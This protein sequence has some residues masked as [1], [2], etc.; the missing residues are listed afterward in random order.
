MT[1][2]RIRH[3]RPGRRQPIIS[4]KQNELHRRRSKLVQSAYLKAKCRHFYLNYSKLNSVAEEK[5]FAVNRSVNRSSLDCE[6]AKSVA[7]CEAKAFLFDHHFPS[8]HSFFSDHPFISNYSF[9]G[10]PLPFDQPFIYLKIMLILILLTVGL[11]FSST[12]LCSFSSHHSL[13]SN[14]SN[15]LPTREYS[16]VAQ[17]YSASNHSKLFYDLSLSD[18]DQPN[19]RLA[20]KPIYFHFISNK[21]GPP[22]SKAVHSDNGHM[23]NVHKHLSR[24]HGSRTSASVHQAY[25]KR[26]M[27]NSDTVKCNDGTEAGYYFRRGKNTKKWIVFLEGGW[28][29]YSTFSCNHQR[30]VQMRNFMTSAHLPEK[31][32]GKPVSLGYCPL[33]IVIHWIQL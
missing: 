5:R 9:S 22:H 32:L 24:H 30:W 18:T 16:F 26:Y 17:K 4:R 3:E 7:N 6:P 23:K 12:V 8:D 25:L 15:S 29:C 11:L 1:S 31:K 10:R 21:P 20:K 27:L 33:G 28:F 2:K 14:R 13:S 19:D